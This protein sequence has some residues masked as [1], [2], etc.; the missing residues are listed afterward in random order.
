MTLVPPS[1]VVALADAVQV[2][3]PQLS[4]AEQV[5]H[6]D[7]FLKKNALDSEESLERTDPP[8]CN[9][10]VNQPWSFDVYESTTKCDNC[11]VT[12][13]V[14]MY[15]AYKKRKASNENRFTTGSGKPT[16]S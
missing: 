10:C 12:E 3:V 4:N 6:F 2:Q 14:F 8:T 5:V 9:Y 7:D 11:S 13:S 1:P 15:K 16:G